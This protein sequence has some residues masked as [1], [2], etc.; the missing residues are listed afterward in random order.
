ML[1]FE[2]RAVRGNLP[3]LARRLRPR[4]ASAASGSSGRK[5][6][7]LG[8]ADLARRPEPDAQTNLLS[9]PGG[10][11]RT[12]RNEVEQ[13]DPQ[14]REGADWVKVEIAEQESEASAHRW[15]SAVAGDFGAICYRRSRSQ[16]AVRNAAP[17]PPPEATSP[18]WSEH[19]VFDWSSAPRRRARP[20]LACAPMAGSRDSSA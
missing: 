14:T 12:P 4:R 5:A 9:D 7:R 13:V 10:C 11:C 8:Q 15:L 3:E 2:G 19:G 16:P 6:R 1:N 17:S 18:A 20:G